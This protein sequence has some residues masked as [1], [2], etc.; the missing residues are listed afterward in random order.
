[1]LLVQRAISPLKSFWKHL[2]FT[3]VFNQSRKPWQKFDDR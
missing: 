3:D 1:M 2:V